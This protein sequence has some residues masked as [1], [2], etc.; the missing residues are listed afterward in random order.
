MATKTSILPE[1]GKFLNNVGADVPYHMLAGA[2]KDAGWLLQIVETSSAGQPDGTTLMSFDLLIGQD[3]AALEK[4]DELTFKVEAGP[5]PVSLAARA[6]LEPSLLYLFFGRLPPATAPVVQEVRAPAGDADIELPGERPLSEP[7]NGTSEAEDRGLPGPVVVARHEPDGLPI[8][9][10][11]Y[12]IG[13]HSGPVMVNAVLDEVEAF[14]DRAQAEE[15]VVS[16]ALKNPDLI[17]FVKDLGT[18]TQVAELDDMVWKRRKQ[19]EVPVMAQAPRRRSAA[20]AH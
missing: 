13:G 11:L 17:K 4:F 19:L 20:G 6:R 9:K 8:F 15:Q 5:G 18:P 2:A 12:A 3:Y 10:D 14:L 7:M 1:F 16:L